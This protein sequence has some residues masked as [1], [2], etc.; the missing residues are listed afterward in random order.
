MALLVG[1]QWVDAARRAN[2]KDEVSGVI[3]HIMRFSLHDGPGIRTAVF[4]KGCPLSC[5]WCHNP[6]SQNFEPEVLYSAERCRLC[7]DCAATCPHGAIERIG[8]RMTVTDDCRLCAT[9]VD[10]CG[11]EARSVAGRTM[12]V[13]EILAEVE[14]DVVFFDESGGGVTFTGGEPFGQAELLEGLLQACRERRIHTTVETCGAAARE[15]VLR[16]GRLAD[17]ILYDLKML[18]AERHRLYTGAANRNVLENLEALVAAGLPVIVRIPVVP[19]INDGA[20]D[21]RAYLAKLPLT[22]VDLLPY[23]G[24]GVEKYR[25]LGREYRM[26]QTAPPADRTMAA[27][28]AEMEAVGIPVKIAG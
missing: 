19:G 11:A 4:F 27:M 24:A 21:V 18:D 5:W 3:L 20:D 13:S 7:G 9:C 10:A 15:S 12:T 23:H 16:I 26:Q 28:A 1:S 14:R 2:G 6:E 8:E 22:R 25:R 17:L